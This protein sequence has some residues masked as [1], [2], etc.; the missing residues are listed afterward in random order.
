MRTA[1]SDGHVAVLYVRD[2]CPD[3]SEAVR[4]AITAQRWNGVSRMPW[5][6]TPTVMS[7]TPVQV[8]SQRR[9]SR[10]AGSVEH[11]PLSQAS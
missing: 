7:P 1:G 11:R 4:E 9:R 6:S 8:S 3:Q 5:R 2:G 10:S